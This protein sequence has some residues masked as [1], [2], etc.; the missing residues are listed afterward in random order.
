MKNSLLLI[1]FMLSAYWLLGQKGDFELWSMSA[2]L[3]ENIESNEWESTSYLNDWKEVIEDRTL[4]SAVFKNSKGDVRAEYGNRPIHYYREG[5]LER[6]NPTLIATTTGY[7]AKNQPFPTYLDNSG[8]FGLTINKESNFMLGINC[9][10]DNQEGNTEFVLHNNIAYFQ[11]YFDGIDKQIYFSENKVKYGYRMNAPVSEV[12]EEFSIIAEEIQIPNGYRLIPLKDQSYEK[13]GL[14]YGSL[15]LVDVQGIQVA[16]IRPLVCFDAEN[17]YT[18]GGYRISEG[19]KKTVL[20]LC[21]PNSWLTNSERAY[22][23]FIDPEIAGTPSQWAGGDMPSCMYPDYNSDSILV[24][25]P[26]GV[27]ITGFFITSSFYANPF[28]PAVMSDG[29]MYFSTSCANSQNFTITGENADLAGTAYL[30]SF[31]LKLPLACCFPESCNDTSVYVSMHLARTNWGI[32]CGLNYVL[33]ND[34]TDWP[35][36]VVVYGKT[37]E[38]YGNEFYVSQSPI[39]SNTCTFNA[40]GYAR[41]GV[42]P[43]TFSHPWATEVVVDGEND[44]CSTGATNHVFTLTIPDCPIYC[45]EDYTLLDVPPP[46]ITDACG[47]FVLD[48]PSNSKPIEPATDVI[49]VYDT[50]FCNGEQIEID[51]TSCLDGGTVH[52]FGNGLSGPG[53]ISTL[54]ENN[55]T[56]SLD[57]VFNTYA[58]IGDCTSDTSEL[59]IAVVPN[60][61]AGILMDS[62]PLIVDLPLGLSDASETYVNPVNAWDWELDGLNLSSDSSFAAYFDTPGEYEICLHVTDTESCMDSICEVV[63]VVPAEIENINIITPNDDDINDQLAFQYLEFYPDNEIFIFNRWGNLIYNAK[64][65]DNSWSGEDHPEGVYY[66]ILVIHEIDETYSSFF[67]LKK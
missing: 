66:Y 21:V 14:W 46:V 37:P 7:V 36:R 8:S 60:P 6:I 63:L 49:A 4:S 48:I 34:I 5:H 15:S 11:D 13:D 50:I 10:K 59:T 18:V 51:L 25:I 35:F 47:Q 26:A 9:S 1:G 20:E 42:A 24:N 27:S 32:G 31:N 56:A 45:D 23:V 39:C 41:Y 61:S 28:S 65:Y 67:H 33:Y 19:Q 38:I 55:S 16:L 54:A 62:N 52:H 44:G 30:D 57:V 40:T 17:K 29:T 43:Y 12:A 3:S 2:S 53:S 64:S 22:P 58:T